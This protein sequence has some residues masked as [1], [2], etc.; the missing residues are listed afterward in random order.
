MRPEST[1]SEIPQ[2]VRIQLLGGFSVS[3]GS[4]TIP[5][6]SPR[7]RRRAYPSCVCMPYPAGPSVPSPNTNAYATPFR[8]TS[9]PDLPRPH[10]A[11]ATR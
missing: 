9:A 4:R 11:C 7:S 10:A 1:A 5:Q 6:K 2:T 8:S 3:V